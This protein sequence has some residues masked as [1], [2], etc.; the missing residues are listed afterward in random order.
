LSVSG[1]RNLSNS[2]VVDGLSANDDAAGLAGTSFSHEVIREFQIINAGGNAEFGRASSGVINILTRSGSN[3]WHGRGYGFLRNQRFDARHPLAKSKDPLTQA[4]YGASAGGRLR[5]NRAFLFS[6][7]EQ[8]RRNA[9]GFVTIAPANV[10]AINAILDGIAFQGARIGTGEYGTG[11]DTTNVFVKTDYN[12]GDRQQLTARYS[13]Y[14]IR[15]ENARTVGG[16]NDAS[17]GTRLADR[18]QTVAVTH[19]ITPSPRNLI[20]SRFQYTRSNLSAPGNDLGPA[21]NISGV[22]NFGASTSS[23][24]GRDAEMVEGSV[25]ASFHRGSHVTKVGFDAILNRLTIAFPGRSA[26]A[27]VLVRIARDVCHWS[28]CDLPT[29]VRFANP[30]PIEPELCRLCAG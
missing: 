28:L 8:T 10:Q 7:F 22:A 21:V 4:Q 29:S 24:T 16:L 19:L 25:T 30:V 6:N 15:S 14:D 13:L 17:R 9:A 27:R 3:D 18:D 26:C 20:E 12:F 2:F 11:W 23:P 1:Q 5:A